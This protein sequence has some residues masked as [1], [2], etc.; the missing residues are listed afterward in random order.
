MS[1]QIATGKGSII[2]LPDGQ[3]LCGSADHGIGIT[4]SDDNVLPVE[5]LVSEVL[6]PRNRKE[7]RASKKGRP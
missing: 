6:Q 3:L 2:I 7:R 4:V 1:D 5:M